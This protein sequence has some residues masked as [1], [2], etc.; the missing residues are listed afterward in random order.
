M[1]QQRRSDAWQYIQEFRAH[2]RYR[3]AWTDFFTGRRLARGV[4]EE[5]MRMVF[6]ATEMA[7]LA[8]IAFAEETELLTYDPTTFGGAATAVDRYIEHVRSMKQRTM[9]H[10]DRQEIAELD[11]VRSLLHM[12]AAEAMMEHGD[13]L[14]LKLGRTLARLVLVSLGIETFRD[15]RRMG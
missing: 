1:E 6:E 15:A 13:V 9:E 11:R 8:L 7:R 14:T 3:A 4:T 10:P 12:R 5:E 2:A